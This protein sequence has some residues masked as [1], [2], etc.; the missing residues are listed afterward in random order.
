MCF[1]NFT[2]LGTSYTMSCCVR[3]G[4]HFQRDAQIT[5]MVFSYSKML[6]LHAIEFIDDNVVVTPDI[7]MI[8]VTAPASTE[9]TLKLLQQ[10]LYF[11]NI[12]Q[13]KFPLLCIFVRFTLN[14]S[15]CGSY[16]HEQN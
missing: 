9:I 8:E 16:R 12:L 10:F 4:Y 13:R 15:N 5:A 3:F 1:G 2:C 14:A 7:Q 6:N 11:V